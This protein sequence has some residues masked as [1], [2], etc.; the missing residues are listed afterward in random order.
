MKV[1]TLLI[2]T[3]TQHIDGLCHRSYLLY[4]YLISCRGI[5]LLHKGKAIPLQVLTGPEGSRRLRIPDFLRQSAHE[6]GK[7]VSTGRLYP[8][9]ISLVIISV[10][11]WVNFRAIVR[12]EVLCQWKIPM[13]PSGIDPATFRFVDHYYVRSLIISHLPVIQ[14]VNT[15]GREMTK[16][17]RR[18]PPFSAQ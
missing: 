7:V 14:N 11:G 12:P 18:K 4:Q 1:I 5:S 16:L 15:S 8:Q 10:R 3:N 9:E 2:P 17:L 6:D 13:T